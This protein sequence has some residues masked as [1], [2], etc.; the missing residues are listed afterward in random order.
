[1]M[2]TPPPKSKGRPN[3]TVIV[4]A[5]YPQANVSCELEEKM[6]KR[7]GNKKTKV[8]CSMEQK[9]KGDTASYPLDSNPPSTASEAPVEAE[10]STTAVPHTPVAQS[11]M[12]YGHSAFVASV[13]AARFFPAENVSWQAP[14]PDILLQGSRTHGSCLFLPP[15]V[16]VVRPT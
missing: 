12:K 6:R 11:Q 14:H 8:G 10:P 1:M 9:Y 16:G 7:L 3:R 15:L 4:E 2:V 13:L 5:L